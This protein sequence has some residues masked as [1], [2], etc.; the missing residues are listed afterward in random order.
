[1]GIAVHIVS[2]HPLILHG[3]DWQ[4]GISPFSELVGALYKT[5]AYLLLS[6]SWTLL[7]DERFKTFLQT[8]DAYCKLIPYHQIIVL[9]NMPEE[10]ALLQ[11]FGV[12]SIVCPHN[13]LLD[14]NLYTW[15]QMPRCYTAVINS[16][17]SPFKRIHL[18]C[19]IPNT[20]L[21]TY[22]PPQHDARYERAL[23]D[24]MKHMEWIQYKD[25]VFQG[26]LSAS[27]VAAV[28]ARSGCGL[29]LSDVEGGCFAATEYLLSGLPVVSTP[30]IGGRDLFFHPDYVYTCEPTRKGVNAAVEQAL[31]CP[32]PPQEIRQRTLEIVHR[33]RKSYVQL[34]NEIARIENCP[35]DFEQR[36]P[37]YYCNKMLGWHADKDSAVRAFIKAGISE[38]DDFL[39][40]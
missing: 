5:K 9:A 26:S 32:V 7:D 6:L 39:R 18:A 13:A 21:I 22:R 11:R 35:Q 27:Q 30:N 25:G 23:K 19:D 40:S 15:Q 16:R 33:Y 37:Q 24:S 20:C 34:L 28:Y 36:W 38:G 29:I 1:M 10:Q 3:Y 31:A 4:C 2:T 17:I 14:E 12:A 8:H